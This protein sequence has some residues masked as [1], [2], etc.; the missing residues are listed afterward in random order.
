LCAKIAIVYNKPEVSRYSTLGEESAVVGVLEAVQAV[1]KSLGELGYDITLV[2]LIPPAS[3]IKGEL[4]KLSTDLIFNL[5]EGFGGQADTEALV[6]EAADE[7]KIPYTG[8]PGKVL[9]LALDK[10]KAKALLK[11]AGVRTPDFQVLNPKTVTDFRLHYPA[12]VKPRGEDASHGISETSVVHDFAGLKKQLEKI[13]EEYGGE[14]LIEEFIDGREF[15]ASA[16]G[17]RNC[18]VLPPSE[19]EFSLP[20]NLPRLLSFAAKWDENS[21][22]FSG[23]RV[24]CPANITPAQKR[25]ISQI[26][27]KVFRLFGCRCYARV[28][29]RMDKDGRIHV[30]ELNPNPDISPGTGSARQS[31]AAGMTYTEF[32]SKIIQIATEPIDEHNCNTPNETTGQTGRN[33]HSTEHTGVPS[34]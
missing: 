7:L 22:Y 32:I 8:C 27:L 10:A 21:A 14:A 24:I 28:D 20:E 12:I 5:F 29:L 19:I 15:N 9:R 11:S 1:E 18:I 34:L 13:S 4:A 17:N 23:T 25:T 6:P 2:P 26:V 3:G 30:I 31:A 16:L 33:E